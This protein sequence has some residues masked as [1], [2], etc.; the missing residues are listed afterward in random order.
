[1]V[2][3]SRGP[4]GK[5]EREGGGREHGA[6]SRP[7]L[8]EALPPHGAGRPRAA[9]RGCGS[10][11][12]DGTE[13]GGAHRPTAAPP[14]SAATVGTPRLRSGANGSGALTSTGSGE[15]QRALGERAAATR[16][17]DGRSEPSPRGPSRIAQRRPCTP[18]PRC[19]GQRQS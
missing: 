5:G 14:L 10:R 8:G 19:T 9:V 13:R 7:V 3:P 15:P 12:R 11:A 6:G 17:V 16:E 18:C 2:E 4:A 1:V